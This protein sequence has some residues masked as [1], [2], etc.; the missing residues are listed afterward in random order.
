MPQTKAIQ[1]TASAEDVNDAA[2]PGSSD[3]ERGTI[4]DKKARLAEF[5]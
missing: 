3:S 5:R 2:R 4:L 1:G